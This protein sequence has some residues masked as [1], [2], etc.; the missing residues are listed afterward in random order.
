MLVRLPGDKAP[1]AAVRQSAFGCRATDLRKVR[2][3][4]FGIFVTLPMLARRLD[5][6]SSLDAE[7]R[8]ANAAGACE[9]EEPHIATQQGGFGGFELLESAEARGQ[10]SR[11][12]G[13]RWDRWPAMR[14]AARKH[15]KP[16]ALLIAQAERRCEPP[17]RVVVDQRPQTAFDVAHGSRAD[18]RS[19]RE[20]LLRHPGCQ[21]QALQRPTQSLVD[22]TQIGDSNGDLVSWRRPP[23]RNMINRAPPAKCA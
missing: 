13:R 23:L 1:S 14:A 5:F 16:Q 10:R 22:V 18:S 9:R 19:F 12:P 6:A 21:A 11:Q 17:G 7:A 15:L 8:L 2:Y 3:S 20:L 4:Y